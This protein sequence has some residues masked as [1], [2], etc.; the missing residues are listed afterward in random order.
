[1]NMQLQPPNANMG[2]APFMMAPQ[3][4][5]EVGF[6]FWG[7][8]RRRK[9]LV[10]LGLLA[11]LA[12]GGI[13]N[14][15]CSKVYESRATVTI[16]PKATQMFQMDNQNQF[17]ESTSSF[18]YRHDQLIAED[19]I[20]TKCLIKYD[21]QDLATLRDLPPT[22]QIKAIQDDLT[23][24]QNRE[25][26]S[27]YELEFTS[28]NP[29][30]AQ[31]VLATV[32]S[33]Y[34]KHLDEKYRQKS[35][36]TLE[37]LQKMS[38]RFHREVKSVDSKL[39][40]A[41]DTAETLAIAGKSD[42][43]QRIIAESMKKIEQEKSLLSELTSDLARSETALENGR[44][45]SMEHIWLLEGDNKIPPGSVEIHNNGDQIAQETRMVEELELQ[46]DQLIIMKKYGPGHS[47]VLAINHA[48]SERMAKIQELNEA[49]AKIM[50]I[51]PEQVIQ[52]FIVGVKQQ[53]GDLRLTLS[54]DLAI[55]RENYEKAVKSERA[56]MAVSELS[57]EKE[58]FVAKA[59]LKQTSKLPNGHQQTKQVCTKVSSLKSLDR[60]IADVKFGHCWL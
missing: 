16:Q 38:D 29:R 52:R 56:V 54:S 24:A 20:L 9:W 8:L 13:Y 40:N 26:P 12:V 17:G 53:I 48:I 27:K 44:E 34:Q 6:D 39:Q 4:P 35:S 14:S 50:G 11:G 3:E 22:D 23:V 46:R 33:T 37:L 18:D 32:V 1:M 5:E 21:L 10:F 31:T 47:A 25:E 41:I 51:G 58:K 60:P 30:D 42:H 57:S 59:E 19:N 2:P 43:I 28:L 15:Q 55:Y 36:D 7:V 49:G 45:A